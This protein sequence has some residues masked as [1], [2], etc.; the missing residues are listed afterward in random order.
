MRTRNSVAFAAVVAVGLCVAEAVAQQPRAASDHPIV[1]AHRGWLDKVQTEN[2]IEQ[3][4]STITSGIT[5]VEIDLGTSK[6]G[7]LY[8]LHD[9]TLN[10]TS[11]GTGP[12]RAYRDSGLRDIHLRN[13]ETTSR[14]AIPRFADLLTLAKES[15]FFIMVDLKDGD[16]AIAAAMLREAHMI[17][18]VV[19][20]SFTPA[21][22]A[23]AFAADPVVRVSVLVKSKAQVDDAILRAA[24]HPLAL[25][26]P[27][28]A[29]PALFQY[30]AATGNP[31]ITDAQDSLDL[32]PPNEGEI[33]Y[34]K[35]LAAHPVSLLVTNR[36]VQ[37]KVVL[38]H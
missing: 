9:R 31:V 30:A 22:D 29:E 4:R 26:V 14:E 34:A 25:Y 7:T 28:D 10:R 24:R 16:P 2:S 12:I 21:T 38:R 37:V 36:P 6:D 27:H 33:V 11:T 1:V 19:F 13:S 32:A 5:W 18:R 17:D 20:L 23:K 15:G 35:Y 8:L 3:I